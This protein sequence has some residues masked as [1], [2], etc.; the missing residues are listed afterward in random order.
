M[1][2]SLSLQVLGMLTMS[3]ILVFMGST[4]ASITVLLEWRQR[5]ATGTGRCR[6]VWGGLMLVAVSGNVGGRVGSRWVMS[7]M[8]C[9]LHS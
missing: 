3:S 4:H 1:Q 2:E 7:C 9:H 8:R 6:L 5:E